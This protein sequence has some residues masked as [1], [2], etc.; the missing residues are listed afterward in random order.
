MTKADRDYCKDCDY[1][2]L[3][4]LGLALCDYADITGKCRSP[5]CKAGVGCTCHSKY[6]QKRR[7]KHRR[8]CKLNAIDAAA[9][10][11]I[12]RGDYKKIDKAAA[13]QMYND[14]KNDVEIARAFNCTPGAV[15]FWRKAY[16]LPSKWKPGNPNFGKG[17]D[18]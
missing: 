12:G 8:K 14:G 4:R 5:I 7:K 18:K 6:E 15:R 13:F 9:S 17:E 10:L 1:F 16:N 2:S 3:N 11:G